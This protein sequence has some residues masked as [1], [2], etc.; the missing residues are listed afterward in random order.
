[1]HK[2]R[3]RAPVTGCLTLDVDVASGLMTVDDQAR[4]RRHG[5]RLQNTQSSW[6]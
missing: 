1:M 2:E 4:R 5:D 6:L 3:A